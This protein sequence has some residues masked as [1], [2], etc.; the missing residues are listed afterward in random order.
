MIENEAR[1]KYAQLLRNFLSGKIDNF[2]Y[3]DAFHEI[4]FKSDEGI[5]QIYCD[6]WHYY[7]DLRKH[8]L[9]DPGWGFES[10]ENREAIIRFILFLHS[11]YEYEWPIASIKETILKLLT[12]GAYDR[13]FDKKPKSTGDQTVWPFYRRCDYE[14]AL[15]NPRLLNGHRI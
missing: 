7:C 12:L 1:E 13:Y 10:K 14:R 11:S 9:N 6:V 5:N 8:K 2:K 3:E 15:S 4:D